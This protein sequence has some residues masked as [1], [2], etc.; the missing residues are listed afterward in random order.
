MLTWAIGLMGAGIFS[1]KDFIADTPLNLRYAALLPRLIGIVCAVAG[2]LLGGELMPRNN[3]HHYARVNRIEL[4]PSC[5]TMRRRSVLKSMRC[6]MRRTSGLS[7]SCFSPMLAIGR[8]ISFLA[9]ES[10]PSS[11][12]RIARA[13]DPGRTEE[14]T[15]GYKR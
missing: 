14:R 10:S 3:L 4:L 8:R 12:S 13:S 6:S 15:D 1:S 9:W 2:R 11:W 7:V 5:S